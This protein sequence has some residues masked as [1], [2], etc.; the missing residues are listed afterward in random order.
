[1]PVLRCTVLFA[2]SAQLLLAAAVSWYL[3]RLEIPDVYALVICAVLVL[4][5]CAGLAASGG[6]EGPTLTRRSARSINGALLALIVILGGALL[7][8]EHAQGVETARLIVIGQV[9][10]VAAM[11]PLLNAIALGAIARRTP[12]RR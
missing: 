4:T 6:R 7:A 10:A 8:L 5:A 11:P 12:S 9:I 3:L 1:M 2:S